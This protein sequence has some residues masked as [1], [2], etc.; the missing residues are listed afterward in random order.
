[1]K[2]VAICPK[3]GKVSVENSLETFCPLC[4]N[5][6]DKIKRV[7]INYSAEYYISK[8]YPNGLTGSIDVKQKKILDGKVMEQFLLSNILNSDGSHPNKNTNTNQFQQNSKVKISNKTM[9]ILII[10]AVIVIIYI[11]GS[12][13][14]KNDKKCDYCSN[15]ATQKLGDEE[16][17]DDCYIDRM[18]DIIE[19]SSKQKK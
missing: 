18:G 11:I 9:L 8:V 19:W 5:S 14:K 17:C 2:Y 10:I 6:N 13:G 3:C 15:S 1:M 16:F 7:N 4:S 12:I